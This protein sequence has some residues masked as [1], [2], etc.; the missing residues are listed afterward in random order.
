MTA[1]IHMQAEIIKASKLEQIE[2]GKENKKEFAIFRDI[3]S[4][5]KR[6]IEPK[7][8]EV[9][10]PPPE[11]LRKKPEEEHRVKERDVTAEIRGRIAYE[12]YVMRGSERFALLTV[13]GEFFV[14]GI[15]D[16]AKETINI[17]NIET[18][19]VT[20]QVEANLIEINIKE[21]QNNEIQ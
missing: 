10:Q 7:R 4:P 20:V 5:I 12:G 13:D 6:V 9:S 17:I 2:K 16:I 1:A 3:F 21:D 19:F 8:A 15:S 11:E 18:K 14:V